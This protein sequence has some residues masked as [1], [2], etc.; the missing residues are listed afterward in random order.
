MDIVSISAFMNILWYIFTIIFVLYK[1]TQVFNK[2]YTAYRIINRVKKGFIWLKNKIFKTEQITSYQPINTDDIEYNIQQ[3]E[4]FKE[5]KVEEPPIFSEFINNKS[6][7]KKE[8]LSRSNTLIELGLFLPFYNK[9]YK[10]IQ[11]EEIPLVESNYLDA[12]SQL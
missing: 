7:K 12:N 4:D 10:G 3:S 2:M 5:I 9:D 8:N 6:D 1:F 11:E